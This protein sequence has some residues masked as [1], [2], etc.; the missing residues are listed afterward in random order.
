MRYP[1]NSSAEVTIAVLTLGMVIVPPVFDVYRCDSN[2]TD[3]QTQA[4]LLCYAQGAWKTSSIY[5]RSCK[6]PSEPI[7]FGRA[8]SGSATHDGGCAPILDFMRHE[9][10]CSVRVRAL[11]RD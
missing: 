1:G 2:R 9:S 3:N 5:W 7:L 4:I 11:N 8:Y 6:L 10:R